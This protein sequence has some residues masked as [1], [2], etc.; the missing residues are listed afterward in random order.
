MPLTRQVSVGTLLIFMALLSVILA[1]NVHTPDTQKA[2]KRYTWFE[3]G[4]LY[5]YTIQDFMNVLEQFSFDGVFI[6]PFIL[7]ENREQK[8]VVSDLIDLC[9][10]VDAYAETHAD[11][12]KFLFVGA[13]SYISKDLT[14]LFSTRNY[15]LCIDDGLRDY[16]VLHDHLAYIKS[17][18]AETCLVHFEDILYK[19]LIDDGLV[20]YSMPCFYPSNPWANYSKL[21]EHFKTMREW[22][23]G[24][25]KFVPA[26]QIFG[27]TNGDWIFP[28]KTLVEQGISFLKTLNPY[29]I[30]YFEP[31]S[32]LSLRGE[33]F[34]GFIEHPEMWDLIR[35]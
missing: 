11:F 14:A 22:C 31:W 1:I 12:Q 23:V 13:H 3:C 9:T 21:V 25:A 35:Q 8:Q 19:N 6:Q 2:F 28:N 7:D 18:G 15:V 20:D 27:T 34:E 33:N 30:K 10:N 4:L 24:K 16:T 26:V 29:A 5:K 17:F 32:G